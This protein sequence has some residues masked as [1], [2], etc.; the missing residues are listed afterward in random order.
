MSPQRV[1]TTAELCMLI[2]LDNV[3]AQHAYLQDLDPTYEPTVGFTQIQVLVVAGE[4]HGC[5]KVNLARTKKP[6]MPTYCDKC[7]QMAINIFKE[8]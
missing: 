6:F 8:H 1:I 5:G 3:A 4:S 2:G 7:N